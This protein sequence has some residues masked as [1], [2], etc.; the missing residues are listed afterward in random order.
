[1]KRLAALALAALLV[2]IALPLTNAGTAQ[3]TV[4]PISSGECSAPPAEGTSAGT[5]DPPSLTPN[6]GSQGI[7][8][9]PG[10]FVATP[11][12]H[13]LLNG[14]DAAGNG[15]SGD[16]HCQFPEGTPTGPPDPEGDH[17]GEDAPFPGQGG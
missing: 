12:L 14:V 6:P 2:A 3:A 9:A 15:D 17:A 8:V 5:Q 7:E 11:I 13:T 16:E 4:H 10:I 1:M